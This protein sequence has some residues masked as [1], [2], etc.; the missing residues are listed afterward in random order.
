MRPGI[1]QH[2]EA[3]PPLTPESHGLRTF[4]PPPRNLNYAFRVW[5]T[6]DA[7]RSL[8]VKQA[9]EFIKCLGPDATLSSARAALESA[10]LVALNSI[11]PSHTPRHIHF[12][13]DRAVIVME[14]LRTHVLL[15]D[16]LLAGR[17]FAADGRGLGTF[18]AR[19]HALTMRAGGEGA[20]A[21][22]AARFANE[23][24][25]GITSAY[26]FLKP[27]DPADASNRHSAALDAQVAALRVPGSAAA[28]AA[29]ELEAIFRTKKQ[30]LIHGD[31]HAGSAMVA[32]APREGPGGA[33]PEAGAYAG[34]RL[35]VI[36]PEFACVGPAAFDVGLV[37]AAYAFAHFHHAAHARREAVGAVEAAVR[38]MWD[39]YADQ[40]GELL[41]GAHTGAEAGPGGAP[42]R[43]LAVALLAEVLREAVGFMGA[44]LTRRV[45]GAAHVADLESIGDDAL[46]AGAE[47]AALTCG[48]RALEGWRR[49]ASIDD[50]VDLIA[51]SPSLST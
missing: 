16:E 8:F 5:S 15:R 48:T 36:D 17:A 43:R 33:E 6:A 42:P 37:L 13:A 27:F 32:R 45:V 25:S 22:Y 44:E 2:S 21:P 3:G 12:D 26:V 38:A 4:N 49:V 23:L 41:R 11:A 50:A 18:M 28:S 35:R 51:G 39:E 34:G 40:M 30:C 9:P 31:L 7:T 29:A 10:A 20:G 24:L 14:D 46:R 47:R 19:A 1:P